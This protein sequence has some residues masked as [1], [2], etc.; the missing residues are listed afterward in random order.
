MDRNMFSGTLPS[1]ISQ[2]TKLKWLS[3]SDNSFSGTLPDLSSMQ[4]LELLYLDGNFF[5]GNPS[6]SISNLSKL[7]FLYLEENEF[8]G[9]IDNIAN[10]AVD[11]IA[12]DL[13]SN[14]FRTAD[15]IPGHFFELQKLK[16]LDL[17]NNYLRG[18]VPDDIS[19]QQN[20]IFFSVHRNMMIGSIPSMLQNL[21]GLLHLDLSNNDF[22]G[23]IPDELFEMSGLQNLFLSE[24]PRLTAGPFPEGLKSMKQLQEI[25]LKNT[26]RSGPLPDLLGFDDLVLLDLDQNLFDGTVP[27]NYGT[28]TNLRYLLLNR[29]PSL[30]GRLPQFTQTNNL[31]T[32]L[33]DGTGI[34]GNFSSICNLPAFTLQSELDSD[35]VALADCSD[36]D[37]GIYCPCC[38]CCSKERSGSKDKGDWCSR[39]V[40][41][42]L[43]WTWENGFRRTSRDFG[44]DA[45]LLNTS[46][47]PPS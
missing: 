10:G 25:S 21:D 9:D 8:M 45:E 38:V 39:S 43:D 36:A 17:S 2:F 6:T 5:R 7:R 13:S 20:L 1:C 16:V 26:N 24:N 19:P 30:G 22:D 4:D 23:L 32:I 34:S 40:V 15:G 27:E 42:S 11:L 29:N 46:K 37:S 41:D 44:I 35:V 33:L 3:T 31:V 47:V 18:T 28:L 14:G 12:L